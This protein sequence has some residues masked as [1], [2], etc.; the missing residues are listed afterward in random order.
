MMPL[1]SYTSAAVN[2]LGIICLLLLIA[3]LHLFIEAA[4]M[5]AGRRTVA[6]GALACAWLIT[7]C[8]SL[9]QASASYLDSAADKPYGPGF[10]IGLPLIAVAAMLIAPAIVEILLARKLDALRKGSVGPIS[11]KEA[12]DALPD[13]VLFA[14]DDGRTLL[15]NARAVELAL[16][17][18]TPEGMLRSADDS[19]WQLS[20]TRLDLGHSAVDEL[21]ATDVSE[22]YG[23]VRKLEGR[24]ARLETVNERLRAY[25]ASIVQLTRDEEVLAAK[26]HVHGEMGKALVALRAY[27]HQQAAE[28]NRDAL[29]GIWRHAIELIRTSAI[30]DTAHENSWDDLVA[31]A[32][33]IDVNLTV[34]GELPRDDRQRSAL[35]ALVH[36]CLSNAVRH[37]GART[38]TVRISQDA[39]GVRAT[40]ENDGAQPR[41]PAE[42]TGGLA[43]VRRTIERAGGTMKVR[44]LPRIA[45]SAAFESRDGEHG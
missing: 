15:R 20:R 6:T 33:S 35:I 21:I 45:V 23:L 3:A 11:I 4:A 30:P 27:E 5:Q 17:S 25:S 13:A 7:L 43:N 41:Q 9:T 42:E 19:I 32:R 1:F 2:W 44:W 10:L 31:A 24:N 14:G 16:D 40:I 12:F 28:R 8:V 37:G 26:M 22:E 34:E 38:V 29:L 36:E 18:G 39:A